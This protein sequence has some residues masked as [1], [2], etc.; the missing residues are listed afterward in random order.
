MPCCGLIVVVVI[1]AV[2]AMATSS[3]L[4]S[5]ICNDETVLDGA[6]AVNAEADDAANRQSDAI[7]ICIMNFL[8]YCFQLFLFEFYDNGVI[9][10]CLL[11]WYRF[12]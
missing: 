6:W 1:A 8:F 9:L 12:I 11:S 4:T 3:S 10:A 5:L 2:A 7:E